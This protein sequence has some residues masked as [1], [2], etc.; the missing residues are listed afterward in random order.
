LV[1][2]LPLGTGNAFA[3]SIGLGSLGQAVLAL[4]VGQV[5]ALDLMVTTHPE[6]SVVVASLSVGFEAEFVRSWNRARR[7]GRLSGGLVALARAAMAQTT[8]AQLWLDGASSPLTGSR[9]WS[10][11]LYNISHY[12]F[13]KLAIP[14][15]DPGD[16]AAEAIVYR[17]AWE[18]VRALVTGNASASSGVERRRWRVALV[19]TSG[20]IQADGETIPGREL[21]VYLEPGGLRV[22]AV[23]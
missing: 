20:P 11:G 4:D 8:T 5:R 6:A 23:S 22:I 13:G 3:H 18:Y 2:V 7:S 12:A 15:C 10:A 16:A 14:E 9:V 19:E 1:G 21:A 17:D